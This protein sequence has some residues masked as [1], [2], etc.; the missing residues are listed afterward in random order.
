MKYI[1]F[2]FKNE[3]EGF[4]KNFIF[5]IVGLTL[6][7]IAFFSLNSFHNE[8]VLLIMLI[9]FLGFVITSISMSYIVLYFINKFFFSNKI[10]EKMLIYASYGIGDIIV[11][12]TVLKISKTMLSTCSL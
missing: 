7:L 1:D 9:G 11:M 6:F 12:L 10:K 3:S 8:I 5:T 2:V 4:K